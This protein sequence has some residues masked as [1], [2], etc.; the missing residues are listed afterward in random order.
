MNRYIVLITTALLIISL[1]ACSSRHDVYISNTGEGS[2]SIEVSLDEMLISYSRDLL[3]GFSG[4]NSDDIRLFD[5]DKIIYSISDLDSVALT[6]IN[7]ESAD[8]LYMD[9]IFQDPGNIFGSSEEQQ[10]PDILTFSTSRVDGE[11]IK[12]LS[13]FLS[14]DNFGSALSL[15][16]MNNSE[17]LDTFGP[18]DNP[19]TDEEYL[20]LMEF[21]FEE[22]ESSWKIRSIVKSSEVL[23]NLKIDGKIINCDGCTS[24][25]I[26]SNAIIRI[27]LLDIVTLEKPIEVV[28]E[29]E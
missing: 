7:S 4:S 28:V 11:N 20:D 21:L 14:K 15:L 6:E 16:G 2:V 24:S 17:I 27:P 9:L 19:Y 8:K 1:N 3:G 29:W 22:Y 10:V 26:G 25:E 23:I 12:K 5:P 13:L 18:Q